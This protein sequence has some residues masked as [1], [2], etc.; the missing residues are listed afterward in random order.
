MLN[1]ID[2]VLEKLIE[3]DKWKLLYVLYFVWYFGA[4]IY[5]FSQFFLKG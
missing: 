2:E 1:I 5:L 3:T 4:V